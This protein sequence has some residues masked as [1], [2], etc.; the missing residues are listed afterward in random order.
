MHESGWS[1]GDP[2]EWETDALH[3][4]RRP[5]DRLEEQIRDGMCYSLHSPPPHFPFFV[6]NGTRVGRW[7]G[8]LGQLGRDDTK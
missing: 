5:V 8:Q 3:D 6:L 2:G 4:E 7:L 1:G